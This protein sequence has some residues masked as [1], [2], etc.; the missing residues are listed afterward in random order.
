MKA[1]SQKIVLML[2]V[3]SLSLCGVLTL[4][5][6]EVNTEEVNTEEVDYGVWDDRIAAPSKA[7][8]SSHN[9]ASTARSPYISG[10]L[11]TGSLGRFTEYAIDFKAD[12]AP[13]Y[14]KVSEQT[15]TSKVAG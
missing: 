2:L 15:P 5:T 12:Y 1:R 8:I 6:E 9:A 3:V 14:H 13:P 4:G 7:E 11:K 10:W